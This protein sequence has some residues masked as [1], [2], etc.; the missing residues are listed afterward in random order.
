MHNYGV[1]QNFKIINDELSI[2]KIY[3]LLLEQK[4][5]PNLFK[6]NSESIK[7]YYS[8]LL[9]NNFFL[10]MRLDMVATILYGYYAQHSHD[11]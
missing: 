10:K 9:Q 1:I 5:T 6:L 4:K 8:L 2:M 11:K 3:N 7:L